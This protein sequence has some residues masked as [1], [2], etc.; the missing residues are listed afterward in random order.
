MTRSIRQIKSDVFALVSVDSTKQLKK[1]YPDSDLRTRQAWLDIESDYVARFG[2]MTR[3]DVMSFQELCNEVDRVMAE[4][5]NLVIAGESSREVN[6]RLTDEFY[7]RHSA[8][9]SEAAAIA[10]IEQ[11]LCEVFGMAA[12]NIV[13]FAR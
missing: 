6:T 7:A 9:I 2:E 5:S 8:T 11:G 3:L 10:W 13:P 12:N 1:L 4:E